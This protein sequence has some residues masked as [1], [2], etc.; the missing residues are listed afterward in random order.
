MWFEFRVEKVQS[1]DLGLRVRLVPAGAS[2][3]EATNQ[4]QS[5]PLARIT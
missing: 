5:H 1:V 3:D 4:N 2:V